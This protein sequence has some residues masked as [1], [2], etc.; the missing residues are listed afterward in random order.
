MVLT[1]HGATPRS[2]PEQHLGQGI[3]IGLSDEGRAA[4]TALA[5]RLEGVPFDRVVCS[6]LRRARETADLIAGGHPIESDER[7]LEMDYGVWEGLTYAEIDARDRELRERW[8][9]DPATVA[10]PGGESGDDV[11]R[12]A[13]SFLA[14][15]VSREGRIL[16]VAH[17]TLNRILLSVVLGVPV[18]DYRRRFRQD[19]ANLTVLQFGAE[20]GDDPTRALLV[21]SNDTG[22]LGG[23]APLRDSG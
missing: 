19:P 15:V 14:E 22:H 6:P 10:C 7:L 12:R 11:A 2:H 17:A 23:P 18:R 13:R 20:V 21:A 16:V 1:R 5:R 3:D 9:D 8:V 4:A